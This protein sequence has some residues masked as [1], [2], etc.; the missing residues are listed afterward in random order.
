MSRTTLA[1]A[2]ANCSSSS[3]ISAWRWERNAR[4]AAAQQGAQSCEPRAGWC[5]AGVVV[6]ASVS[7]GRR[8]G[9]AAAPAA[10][11]ACMPC[12][13]HAC[14]AVPRCGSRA[15]RGTTRQQQCSSSRTRPPPHLAA[16]VEAGLLA[17]VHHARAAV[18]EA[19]NVIGHEPVIQHDV[20]GLH[21]LHRAQRQQPGVAGAGADEVHAA[22]AGCGRGACKAVARVCREGSVVGGARSSVA[23][24]QDGGAGGGGGAEAPCAHRSAGARAAAPGSCWCPTDRPSGA[25]GAA[26]E[27]AG[28][29]LRAAAAAAAVGAD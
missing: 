15:A 28:S 3:W 25:A 23:R 21:Q 8:E 5:R 7:A 6:R 27:G 4:G 26:G 18:H 19:Q 20:R 14:C 10:R 1:P 24:C 17:H 13:R 11:H 9:S 2:S 12:V 16:R 29:W 22:G